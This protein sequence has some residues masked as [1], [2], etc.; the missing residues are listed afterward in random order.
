VY[1][2]IRD[3]AVDPQTKRGGH[4]VL[5]DTMVR[6]YLLV[7]RDRAQTMAEY[8]VVLAVIAIGIFAALGFLSGSIS[9]ALAKVTRDI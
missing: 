7:H 9:N 5:H 4:Q 1:T 6:L 2:Q 8:A 3:A